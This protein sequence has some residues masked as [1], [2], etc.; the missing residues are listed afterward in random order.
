MVALAAA[1][2]YQGSNAAIYYVVGMIVYFWAYSEGEV[3]LF[4][5]PANLL[6]LLIMMQVVVAKPWSLPPRAGSRTGKV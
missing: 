4:S 3:C 2:L 6:L 5:H 1:L